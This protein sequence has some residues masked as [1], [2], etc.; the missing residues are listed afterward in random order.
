MIAGPSNPPLATQ[1]RP[2]PRQRPQID[3]ADR[4]AGDVT[5]SSQSSLTSDEGC[6]HSLHLRV[7]VVSSMSN[8][9]T[10]HALLLQ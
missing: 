8:S 2:G 6:D 5:H 7:I 4:S 3:S 9:A 10:Q 1:S